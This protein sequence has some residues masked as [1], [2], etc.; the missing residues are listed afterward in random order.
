[1]RSANR[2]N[3]QMRTIEFIPHF[4]LHA[5]GSCLVSFGNTKVICAATIE[6]KV[7][8]FLK[9]TGKGWINAEYSLLPCSTH[10]RIDREV[11][12][13]QP[14]GRTH[15]IQR[16]IA[17][18]LRSAVD[19]DAL[20]EKQIKVDCDVI[21]ADGGTRVA[22]ICGGC[23]ALAYALKK[24]HFKKSPLKYFVAGISCGILNDQVIIDLDYNEDSAAQVD[25]NFVFTQDNQLV[26]VQG[27][28]ENGT[29]SD[30]QLIDMLR[31]AK[32]N[33]HAIFAAQKGA[34]R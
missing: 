23:V 15:E 6:N 19:L 2:L 5:D 25:A 7:P 30:E 18:S 33:M 3:T 32:N 22:S 9:N 11:S 34:V 27:T 24:M 17:R 29:F 16:L 14:S 13:G 4:L 10:T 8:L 26:E 1:M 28:G 31:L 12:K 20:G 21:Q